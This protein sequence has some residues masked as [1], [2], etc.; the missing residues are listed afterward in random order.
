M[1]R[2]VLIVFV[3][4]SVTEINAALIDR[5]GGLFYDT[6]LDIT[7]APSLQT[8]GKRQYEAHTWAQNL[9][10]YDSVR[11]VTYSDWRLPSPDGVYGGIPEAQGEMGH[12]YFITLGNPL[13]GPVSNVGPFSNLKVTDP[14]WDTYWAIKTI[15]GGYAHAF[16]MATGM[17]WA[18]DSGYQLNAL[19][20]RDGDVPEPATLLLFGL[21][22]LGLLRKRKKCL[23]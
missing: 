11:D 18:W 16:N 23:S 17:Q 20:V 19:A 12:L 21:G 14:T 10:Y 9:T 6:E 5:G 3:M 1:K 13:G 22:G 8:T 4:V 7:W 15:T 2:I